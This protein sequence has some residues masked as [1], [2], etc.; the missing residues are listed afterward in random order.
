MFLFPEVGDKV[1]VLLPG[2]DPARGL[3]IGGVFGSEQAPD[4]G[5]DRQAQPRAIGLRTGGGQS[6]YL[7]GDKSLARLETSGGDK[8]EMA[9]GVG[10]TAAG[11]LTIEAK[12][13]LSISAQGD[14]II[15]APGRSITI[16]ARSV[17]FVQG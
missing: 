9:D 5:E 4:F 11:A 16:R 6:F 12:G 7:A 17:D 1:I 2:G 13:D 10:L 15:E 3:V 8:L 14:I